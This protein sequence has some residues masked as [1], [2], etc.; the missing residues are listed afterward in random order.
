MANQTTYNSTPKTRILKSKNKLNLDKSVTSRD[1]SRKFGKR[2]DIV[3]LHI[4]NSNGDLLASDYNFTDYKF[5]NQLSEPLSSELNIDPTSILNSKGFRTGKYNLVFNIHRNRI[6]NS[7]SPFSIKEISPSR[8][9]LRIIAHKTNNK[10]LDINSRTYIGELESSLFFKEFILNFKKNINPL[11]V[12]LV[13]NTYPTKYELLIK[14]LEPLPLSISLGNTFNIREELTDPIIINVNLG[15]PEI[16]D[17]SIP[18]K[19]PNFKIDV[20]LNNSIPSSFKTYDGILN[21]S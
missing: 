3:E 10:I 9:E 1:L 11:G 5:P 12:N 19:G 4:Y 2:E 21:Y 15:E 6:I 8:H 16:L 14:L 7:E 17:T 13:L 20:R 18:L